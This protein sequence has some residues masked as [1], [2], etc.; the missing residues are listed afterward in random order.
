LNIA[1]DRAW[2][3]LHDPGIVVSSTIDRLHDKEDNARSARGSEKDGTVAKCKEGLPPNSYPGSVPPPLSS[4][5]RATRL[6]RPCAVPRAIIIVVVV[7]VASLKK[8]EKPNKRQP[9]RVVADLPL[10]FSRNS[11]L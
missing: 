6:F 7:V 9:L 1:Q 11:G 5:L 10:W 4:L 2:S 3:A 8:I